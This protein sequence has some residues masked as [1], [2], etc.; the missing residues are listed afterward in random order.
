[1][2]LPFILHSIQGYV[3]P[4]VLNTAGYD[5]KVDI[6]SAGV[7]VYILLC[8]YPPF[9]NEDHGQLFQQIRD[10][11]YQFHTEY[12]GRISENAKDFVCHMLCL[13]PHERWDATQ[14][15]QHPWLNDGPD[16]S[17]LLK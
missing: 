14:L 13:N 2:V 12:W 7:I 10:A 3:A 17:Y 11:R 4:E 8:G 1:M 5:C 15:L 16:G 9:Y 6:W